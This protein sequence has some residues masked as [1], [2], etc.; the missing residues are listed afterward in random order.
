VLASS[1]Q[2]LRHA[3]DVFSAACDHAGMNVSTE[4]TDVL[5]LSRNPRQCT[6]LQVNCNTLQQVEKF[7]WIG[8]IL[9]SDRRRNKESDTRIGKAIAFL[10]EIY[11]SVLTKRLLTNTAKLSAFK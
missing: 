5:C 3:L 4:M 2:D 8:V 7:K 6:L 11:R 1:E 9:T 10:R